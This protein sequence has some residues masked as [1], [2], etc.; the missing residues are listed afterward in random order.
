MAYELTPGAPED[1]GICP[2]R[3]EAVFRLIDAGI[4]GGEAPGAALCVAR[5]GVVVAHRGFG[6]RGPAP[7]APP[8]GR[9]TIFLVASITKSVTCAAAMRLVER[10]EVLLD[11]PVCRFVPEFAA[12]GKEEVQIRHLLTHTSGLPDMLPDNRELRAAHTP[13]S[14]FIRRI[15]ETPL[16]F[17]PGTEIRYQSTGTAML[18]EIV[19][20]VTGTPLP[21]FLHETFFRPLGMT[22]TS[23]GIRAGMEAALAVCRLEPEHEGT[24]WGWNSD[25]WR[26][27]GA[28]WGGMFATTRD[29]V[30]F[31]RMFSQ[32]GATR[33]AGDRRDTPV[34]GAATV[35]AMTTDQTARIPE[36]PEAARRTQAWGFGWRVQP[37]GPG[38][39]FGDLLGPRAFGHLGATGTV[40]WCDPDLDLACALFTNEPL[41]H[42]RR[43]L[44]RVS[45]AVA[46]SVVSG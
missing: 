32:V 42:C 26:R 9:E 6:R 12:A 8:V 5:R 7:D 22:D 34:L 45:N 36:L 21:R 43:F 11:D 37:F 10:G 31:G 1:V 39:A 38:D 40:T 29:V 35:A 2:G 19:E 13:L 23:L 4:T 27:F 20:R 3:L 16:L 30:A 17:S 25:Y 14:G 41:D 46:A 15:C 18:G 24:D 28:P 33:C 44:A